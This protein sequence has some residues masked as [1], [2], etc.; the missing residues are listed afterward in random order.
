MPLIEVQLS[1]KLSAEDRV[2]LMTN[3]SAAVASKLG[4][5]ESYMMVVLRPDATLMMGGRTDPAALV[6]VR[7]VG[8]ISPAQARDIAGAVS[9]SLAKV[10]GVEED[11][12]YC[13]FQGVPG[14][15]W[16]QGGNTFG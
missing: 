12:V 10:S 16:A 11:R 14:A 9:H 1:T 13:V 2:V 4:K 7:S 8:T 5:P 15:M 6:K 3:L